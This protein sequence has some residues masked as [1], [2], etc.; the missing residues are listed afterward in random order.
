[1]RVPRGTVRH[2]RH[3]KILELTKGYRGMRSST[4]HQANEAMMKAG[5][6]AYKDRK[7]KKRDFRALWITRISAAA[8]AENVSYSRLVK[9]MKEKN[10]QL[11]RKV[12]SELA[13]HEPGI[14]KQI[15]KEA[16]VK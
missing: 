11:D 3:K 14:F 4:F 8:R 15:L 13:V 9:A 6:H 16:K 12:L 7:R 1:M 5:Q 10:I 2:R